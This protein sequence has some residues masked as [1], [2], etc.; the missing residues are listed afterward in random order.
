MMF[1]N[2]L[3]K[4]IPRTVHTVDN[5]TFLYFRR[6]LWQRVLSLYDITVPEHWDKDYFLECLYAGGRVAV[7]DTQK[8]GV[9]PQYCTF[10]ELNVFY[11]PVFACV[12]NHLLS[13]YT[14]LR[15]GTECELITLN[16]DY[17]GLLDTVNFYAE[18]MALTAST[19]NAN[20]FQARFATLFACNN[21]AQAETYKQMYDKISE[22]QPAVFFDKNLLDETGKLNIQQF[23]NALHQNYIA[24][25]LLIDLKKWEV[26]FNLAVGIPDTA[27]EKKERLIDNEISASQISCNLKYNAMYERLQDCFDKVN[28]KY[29]LDLTISK[30]KE[31][32]SDAENDD[33]TVYTTDDVQQERASV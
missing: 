26:M 22:G 24:D 6:F 5:T 15:I 21:K 10:H 19:A 4:Q 29:N 17:E 31:C 18:K 20:I 32:E 33:T 1:R 16:S 8:F 11:R 13:E 30:R 7:F 14:R 23:N 9:I 12:S 3:F 25:N 2:E 27:T 28:Q